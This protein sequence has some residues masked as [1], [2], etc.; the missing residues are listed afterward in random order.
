MLF[1]LLFSFFISF[2]LLFIILF[3]SFIRFILFSFLSWQLLS[4]GSQAEGCFYLGRPSFLSFSPQGWVD[5]W[6]LPLWRCSSQALLLHCCALK[7]RHFLIEPWLQQISSFTQH[8]RY[9]GWGSRHSTSSL[10][11]FSVQVLKEMCSIDNVCLKG[12]GISLLEGHSVCR[13]LHQP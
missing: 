11:A 2:F 4:R 7:T 3:L 9:V 8:I 5:R 10:I 6:P 12:M 13:R 1:F